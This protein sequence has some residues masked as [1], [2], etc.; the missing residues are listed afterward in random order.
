M[1]L[2]KLVSLLLAGVMVVSLAACTPQTGTPSE[3]PGSQNPGT[4]NPTVNALPEAPM[5][6]ELV[7]AGKLPKVEERIPNADNVYVDTVDATGKK[8]SIGTYGGVLKLLNG[9]GG[10]D[11]SRP[12]MES[13]IRYNTDGTYSPN[14]I[15]SYDISEDYKVWTFHLREG[16]R[17]SDGDDFNADDITFWYYMCH[18]NNFDGK[19]SWAA[20]IDY[21]EKDAE[22]NET[23]YYAKL[24][25]VD[26]Y[27]VTWTFTQPKLP[28][29]FI[30][31][32][33]FKWCWA[34]S[35]YLKDLIPETWYVENEYWAKPTISEEQ[36][37]INAKAKGIDRSSIKDLGKY[38][39]YYYWQTAGV[40][41]LNS[42][43]LT[44][45]EGNNTKD[46]ALAILERNPYFWKVDAAGQQLPYCDAIHFIKTETEG[47]DQLMFRSDELDVIEVAM[48]NI[49]AIMA[50]M[51]DKAVLRTYQ[52]TNWGS[53]QITFNYTNTD[54]DYAALFSNVKFREAM[55][56]CVDRNQ[57]SELLSD[58]FLLPGQACPGEGHFGYD[59]DWEKKWT[60]YDVA[61]AQKLLE[62]CGLKKGSDGFYD[63]ANGKDLLVV[64][65]TYSESGA[66]GNVYPVLEQ[67]FKA[68]GIN[69]ANQ[70]LAMDAYD[71]KIDANEWVACLAPHTS[72]G[73]LSL[74][75]RVAPF[76]PV[77]Q[78]A[79]WYGEYGTWY[80]TGGAQGVKPTGEMA[81]LIEIYEKWAK[82][83]DAVKRDQYA[84][85]IYKIHKDNLWSIAY[86]QGGGTYN[87]VNSKIQNYPEN[88]VS[89]DL[90]Q[91]SNIVHFWTLY[92]TAE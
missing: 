23:V 90:Y 71:Q 2:K 64:F 39:T 53:Y 38:T 49:A 43:N 46:S 62:E 82:E 65:T 27:T 55:S 12:V 67:Y 72:I 14:V 6:T 83:P 81:K 73:G 11:L 36:A 92:K 17:W 89:A 79:E 50:D 25:K 68:V 29:D 78:A 69:C 35:H 8:L 59:A 57:V 66:S 40:P 70:D 52:G 48:E 85:E 76:V 22:G 63:F 7:N 51:G 4:E 3:N 91:Y 10:W 88:L 34:P 18:L 84:L 60:G 28:A 32:G 20:L 58:G 86:L 87:L 75:D 31:N 33:D 80:G 15:K 56:I 5:L 77:Q 45:K 54:A 13:I 21:K 9:G 47:Q 37:L 24:T 1:K 42:Y 19:K 30:E 74:K 61:K 16:M 41:T 44:T 26:N